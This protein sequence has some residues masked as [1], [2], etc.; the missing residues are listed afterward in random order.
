MER[1]F[2]P[3]FFSTYQSYGDDVEINWV[4]GEIRDNRGP[5]M[6]TLSYA[7]FNRACGSI[8]RLQGNDAIGLKEA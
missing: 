1:M 6:K 2:R 8:R 5:F 7:L 4:T 3:S